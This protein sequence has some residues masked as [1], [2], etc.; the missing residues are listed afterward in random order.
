MRFDKYLTPEERVA[1]WNRGITYKLATSEVLPSEFNKM[2]KEAQA[3]QPPL[4]L[5][6]MLWMALLAGVP[7]GIGSSLVGSELASSGSA[8][9]ALKK[10]RD[11][12]RDITD[13]IKQRLRNQE[14]EEED[15]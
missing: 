6:A 12:T 9:A 5:K 11:Y 14:E 13:T 4:P 3:G 1:A 8:N 15:A 10:K 2:C 7:L